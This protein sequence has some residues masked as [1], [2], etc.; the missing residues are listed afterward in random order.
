MSIWHFF[1]CVSKSENKCDTKKIELVKLYPTTNDMPLWRRE[2]YFYVEKQIEI[3][4]YIEISLEE[5]RDRFDWMYTMSKTTI[6]V[7]IRRRGIKTF[8][9]SAHNVKKEARLTPLRQYYSPWCLCVCVAYI[10]NILCVHNGLFVSFCRYPFSL[11]NECFD[12]IRLSWK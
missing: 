5:L 4:E 8:H 11:V 10:Q 9:A 1:V 2:K 12:I 6:S 7:Y 3:S